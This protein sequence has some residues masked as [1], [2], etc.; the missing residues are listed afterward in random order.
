MFAL[1]CASDSWILMCPCEPTSLAGN[2]TGR[3]RACSCLAGQDVASIASHQCCRD[4]VSYGGGLQQRACA[5][6]TVP[7]RLMTFG[8]ASAS[9]HDRCAGGV[10]RCVSCET[11]VL[12]VVDQPNRLIAVSW[13]L[14]D[15]LRSGS[16]P[17][18]R[19][20][21]LFLG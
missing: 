20:L 3:A 4:G 9:P 18:Q 21:Q 7:S 19:P 16:P 11:P 14:V 12:V 8:G 13:C 1:I 10:R 15:S 2:A 6:C 5:F 17:T